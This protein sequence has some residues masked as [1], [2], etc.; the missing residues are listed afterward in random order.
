MR[1]FLNPFK[2]SIKL[3]MITY[4]LLPMDKSFM[5]QKKQ[6]QLFQIPFQMI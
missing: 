1:K 3:F 2:K 5:K 4:V 6:R